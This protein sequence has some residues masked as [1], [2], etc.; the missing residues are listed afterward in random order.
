LCVPF[1]PA[2]T[3]AFGGEGGT[4]G[5]TS[6]SYLGIDARD[7]TSDRVAALKLK[8]EHGVEVTMVDQDAPAGKAGI[9]ERDVILDVNGQRL[10]SMEQLRRIIK[11]TPS[12]R[13][14]TLGISRDGQPVTVKATLADRRKMVAMSPT[15][16]IPPVPPVAAVPPMNAMPGMSFDVPN[17]DMH[18]RSSWLGIVVESLSPQLGEYFGVRNGEG[19][20]VNSVTKGSPAEKAGLR[21]GDVIVRVDKDRIT[22]RSDWRAAMRNHHSGKVAIGFYRD[23]REQTITMM[24][25]EDKGDNSFRIDMPDFDYD[26]LNRE[27][28]RLRPELMRA[29][30]EAAKLSSAEVQ[31]AMREARIQM[32]R[33][34]KQMRL[35]MEKEQKEME[36]AR[37]EAEKNNEQ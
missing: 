22:G 25:P 1:S 37:K 26:A 13:V 36:K 14:I 8:D 28:E 2:D 3:P 19:V 7:V 31:K 16:P 10:E 12:G 11:E 23:R 33:E 17:M 27:M 18:M 20:L 21:A 9:K 5:Y 35:E 29:T 30:A 6:S 24:M 32:E 15:S 4:G 34:M